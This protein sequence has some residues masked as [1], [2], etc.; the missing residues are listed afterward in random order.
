MGESEGRGEG[1]REAV[2][3]SEVVLGNN[4]TGDGTFSNL[5]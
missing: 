4:E 5:R 2:R 1:E 3:A